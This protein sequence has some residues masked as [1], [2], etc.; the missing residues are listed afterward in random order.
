MTIAIPDPP[1]ELTRLNGLLWWRG[2]RSSVDGPACAN[3]LAGRQRLAVEINALLLRSSEAQARIQNDTNARLAKAM[4][5]ILDAHGRSAP[6]QE[7]SRLAAICV[8][9]LVAQIEVLA[10]L[11][12]DLHRLTAAAGSTHPERPGSTQHQP[13]RRP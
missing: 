2:L 12:Q 11:I 4:I 8:E 6:L 10:E 7:Q 1:T 9:G 13:Q 5:Q 3:R